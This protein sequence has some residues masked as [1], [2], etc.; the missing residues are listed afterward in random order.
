[1][2]QNSPPYKQLARSHL[3]NDRGGHTGLDVHLGNGRGL[4][5]LDLEHEAQL[6]RK[7]GGEGAVRVVG[8]GRQVGSKTAVAC[9]GERG[10]SAEWS[11]ERFGT[12]ECASKSWCVRLVEG[13]KRRRV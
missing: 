13:E 5:R 1:M 8:G 3:S 10:E 4:A 12:V 9:R 11:G 7:Q 6:L 2:A